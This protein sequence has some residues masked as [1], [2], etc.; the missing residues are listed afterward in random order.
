[1][2]QQAPADMA[3]VR[4]AVKQP[5]FVQLSPENLQDIRPALFAGDA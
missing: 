3:Q 4:A 5:G 2:R 1:M